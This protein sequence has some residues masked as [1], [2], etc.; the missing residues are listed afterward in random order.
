MIPRAR[1]P[2]T[3]QAVPALDEGGGNA[4]P[5]QVVDGRKAGDAA[6]DDDYPHSFSRTTAARARVN[7]GESFS[8]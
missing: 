2:R 5:G 1:R 3:A 4:V 7:A 6:A 8:D